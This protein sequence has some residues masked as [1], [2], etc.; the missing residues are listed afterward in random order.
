MSKRVVIALDV[1]GTTIDA[2]CVSA[3]GELIGSVRESG[4]PGEDRQNPA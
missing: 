1:G 2:A 4:R 3:V